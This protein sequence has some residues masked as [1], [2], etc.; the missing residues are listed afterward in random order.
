M[1]WLGVG[2]VVLLVAFLVLNSQAN[3]AREEQG[4]I[5]SLRYELVQDRQSPRGEIVYACETAYAVVNC[6]ARDAQLTSYRDR[7]QSLQGWA[8]SLMLGFLVSLVTLIVFVRRELRYR[9]QR[10]IFG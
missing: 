4:F 2:V 9:R 7:A 3:Q 10:S 8:S 5:S 6:E 1:Y